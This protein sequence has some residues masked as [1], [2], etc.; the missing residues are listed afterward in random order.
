MDTGHIEAAILQLL[1]ERAE[2]DSVIAA[3]QKR[4]GGAAQ[5]KAVLPGSN[6]IGGSHASAGTMVYRGEFFNLSITKAA[7][8]LLKRFGRP[9]KTPEIQEAFEKA[10]YE[11]KSKL[12][13]PTIYT[14]LTRSRD[15]VKVLPDTWDLSERHPEAAAK[16][17]QELT[18]AKGS[19]ASRKRRTAKA[20]RATEI[21]NHNP[22]GL[23]TVA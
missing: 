5:N 16:K 4:V 8:K 21:M 15:F 22:E 23:K 2:L 13:R 11:I 12:V 14:S 3:L 9:L 10:G 7:E 17:E 19:K 20:E 18:K 6:P 1:Q